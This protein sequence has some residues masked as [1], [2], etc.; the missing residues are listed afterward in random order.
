MTKGDLFALR[1]KKEE[2]EKK[3]REIRRDSRSLRG[4]F[5]TDEVLVKEGD[6]GRIGEIRN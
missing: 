4:H 1:V 6:G 5:H 2:G 3:E